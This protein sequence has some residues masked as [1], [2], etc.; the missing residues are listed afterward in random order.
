MIC[1]DQKSV[2]HSIYIDSNIEHIMQG[3][4]NVDTSLHAYLISLVN[5]MI[6]TSAGEYE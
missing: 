2:G 1:A 5:S 3:C 4:N 6:P